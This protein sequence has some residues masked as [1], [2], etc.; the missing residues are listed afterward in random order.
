[1]IVTVDELNSFIAALGLTAPGEWTTEARTA[2]L[3]ASQALLEGATGR[4][5]EP[6]EGS[7]VFDGSG[8]GTLLI[9]D[10]VEIT[11]VSIGTTT[12]GTADYQVYPANRAP[13]WRLLRGAGVWPEGQQNIT[14]AA[15]WGYGA[16]APDD[17]KQACLMLATASLLAGKALGI[18]GESVGAVFRSYAAGTFSAT[19][20]GA[21]DQALAAIAGWR[22]FVEEAIRLHG[23]RPVA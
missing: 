16:A 12:L 4:Q 13:K 2:K 10:A 17:L 6:D 20:G 15:T 21:G 1:M 14:V 22:E 5:L 23:R 9:D 3:A 7:R 18:A 19:L 8:V 11:A